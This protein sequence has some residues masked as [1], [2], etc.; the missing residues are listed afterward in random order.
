MFIA[1]LT[2]TRRAWFGAFLLVVACPLAAQ[3]LPEQIRPVVESARLGTGYA[4]LINLSAT[5]D[6]SAA[7]YRIDTDGSSPTLDVLRLPYQARW[8]AL[9][10]DADLYWKVAGGYLKFKDDFPFDPSPSVSGSIGSKWSAY[11]VTG[12]LLAKL[13]L[14]HS[15]TLEPALDFGVARL[16]NQ[17]SYAGAATA[18]QPFLDGLMFN[19]ETS[20]WLTTPSLALEWSAAEATG[21]ATVRG[22][23]ARSWVSSF[24]ATD[25][26]QEFN[27]TANICSIRAEYV[28]PSDL[29]AFG[30]PLGWVVYG[31]Y[32]GFFGANR[33]ALGFTSVAEIGAGLEVPVS[34]DRQDSERVRLAAGYLV[35]ADV[36]G[37]T[38]G[39]SLGY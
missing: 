30:R 7:S 20:A 38:V 8:L 35:G 14:G 3:T 29:R 24:D 32:A 25:P 10:P 12:G 27:E 21:K 13:R 19:W 18:L 2:T 11:S 6:V 1:G 36:T 28:M 16:D 33:N 26:V 31:G 5:P 17:A 37:W 15:F 22:H 9:S 39:V 4:Q 34:P 23:V